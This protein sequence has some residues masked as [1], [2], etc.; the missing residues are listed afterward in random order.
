MNPILA[1]S[2]LAD[3]KPS[4]EENKEGSEE[5]L[6]EDPSATE[7]EQMIELASRNLKNFEKANEDSLEVLAKKVRLCYNLEKQEA[8]EKIREEEREASKK[9]NGGAFAT[10]HVWSWDDCDR[11]VITNYHP[12]YLRD[13]Y[14]N[15][16]E[17][18]NRKDP[19]DD[20]SY[21]SNVE[22]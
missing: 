9:E 1:K 10:K 8:L 16:E 15:F 22:L 3:P 17:Y 11:S 21:E 7:L 5:V 12:V 6:K 4:G 18:M 2:S 20:L 19:L 14:A 13:L